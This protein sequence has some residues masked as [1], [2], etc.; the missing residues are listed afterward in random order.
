MSSNSFSCKFY[1][2]F[3]FSDSYVGVVEL[4]CTTRQVRAALKQKEMVTVPV[5]DEYR[6][7]YLAASSSGDMNIISVV[8]PKLKLKPRN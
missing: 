2:N 6:L 5:L 8:K 7:P 3:R 4:H 1:D